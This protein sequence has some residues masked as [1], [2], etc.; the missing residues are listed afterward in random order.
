MEGKGK[1]A[2]GREKLS[3][4]VVLTKASVDLIGLTLG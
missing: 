1:E 3:C 4:D 2:S